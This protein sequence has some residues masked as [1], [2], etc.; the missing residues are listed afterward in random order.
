MIAARSDQDP[1]CFPHPFPPALL[2]PLLLACGCVCL[3]AAG[4]GLFLPLLPTTPFLLL[5][6]ACFARS[7]AR[8]HAWLLAHRAFGPILDDW[9]RR[10]AIRRRVKL[11]TTLLML[12]LLAPPLLTG[13]F[14]PALKAVAGATAAAALLFVW[15]RPEPPRG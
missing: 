2:R 3:A 11:V 10:R 8:L 1:P 12:A 4:A 9:E 5:A 7:S 6:A 15:T 14:A 13:D